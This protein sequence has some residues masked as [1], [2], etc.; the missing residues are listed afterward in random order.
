[1]PIKG[2]DKQD[3]SL[4]DASWIA[5]YNAILGIE[6]NPMVNWR[7]G[8]AILR[9]TR[10]VL[11]AV[12]LL[13]ASLPSWAAANACGAMEGGVVAVDTGLSLSHAVSSHVHGPDAMENMHRDRT[14][15]SMR[16]PL[17]C[18]VLFPPAVAPTAFVVMTVTSSLRPD[19]VKS[20][21]P[22]IARPPPRLLA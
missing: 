9:W 13:T 18:V 19:A 15:C 1:M 8:H 7:N 10:I 3:S 2:H 12:M 4:N 14:D 21:A 20:I 6:R 5:R 17:G 22:R 16:C 11:A